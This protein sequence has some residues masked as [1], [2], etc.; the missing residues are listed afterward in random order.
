MELQYIASL[1]FRNKKYTIPIHLFVLYNYK[2]KCVPLLHIQSI[3]GALQQC[4]VPECTYTLPSPVYICGTP[5]PYVNRSVMIAL[6]QRQ[7]QSAIT[8][9]ATCLCV[10]STSC[11]CIVYGWTLSHCYTVYPN[12]NAKKH[13]YARVQIKN[14]VA[15]GI[16]TKFQFTH[17]VD[18]DIATHKLRKK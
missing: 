6:Y 17:N 13:A 4:V 8:K 9:R 7:W 3:N 11:G 18:C 2:S 1:L 14:T 15:N 16:Q 5:Y 10:L 12:P